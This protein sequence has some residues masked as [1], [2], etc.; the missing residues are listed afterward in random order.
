[1]KKKQEQKKKGEGQREREG[2]RRISSIGACLLYTPMC[3]T[4]MKSAVRSGLP[5]MSCPPATRKMP[6][7]GS[8]PV[9]WYALGVCWFGGA[10]RTAPRA[11]SRHM[12]DCV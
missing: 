6:V 11:T 10:G 3:F 8:N 12:C 5:E 2:E 7:S 4:A 9:V 1:M